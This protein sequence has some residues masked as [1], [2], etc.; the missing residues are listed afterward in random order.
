MDL[1][2]LDVKA[3]ADEGATL[4]LEH[5]TTGEL[6]FA[7]DEKKKPMTIKLV[8]TD[9]QIYNDILQRRA[10]KQVNKRRPDKIDVAE[11]RRKGTEL[12]ARCTLSWNNILNGGKNT[13]HSYEAAVKLYE[14]FPWIREQVDRFVGDRSNFLQG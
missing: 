1:A 2:N 3:A 11:A 10:R 7:D 4:H 13:K 12:L 6:L 5:P 14:E 8:G 9:S